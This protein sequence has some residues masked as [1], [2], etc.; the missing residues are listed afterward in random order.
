MKTM[1]LMNSNIKYNFRA[2]VIAV[3]MLGL[4]LGCERKDED[5]RPATFPN[6]AEIFIDGFSPGLEFN[7][8][9]DSKVTAF[10]VDE[11]VSFEDVIGTAS[12]R[13]NIPN[14]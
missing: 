5:I 12:M 10:A 11:N 8:F 3:I 2:L 1:E 14:E 6:T 13:F 4:F 9:G 7:A